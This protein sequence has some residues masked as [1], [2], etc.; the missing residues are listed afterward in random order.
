MAISRRALLIGS[1]ALGL[2]GAAVIVGYR[3]RREPGVAITQEPRLVGLWRFDET[4][5]NIATDASPFGNDGLLVAPPGAKVYGSGAFAGSVALG[6]AERS[7]VSILASESLNTLTNALTVVAYAYPR[8]LWTPAD[9]FDGHIALVQ[10]QWR[11][12]LHPDLFYLGY[13]PSNGVLTYKWHVGLVDEEPSIYERTDTRTPTTGA[14]VHLAGV[15][16]GE[17]GEMSL[18]VDG[19]LIATQ[20]HKGRIRLDAESLGRPVM[21]GGELNGEGLTEVSAPFNGHVGEVRIYH[22]ALTGAEVAVLASSTSP[23]GGDN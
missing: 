6:G 19:D 1:T 22:R 16:D 2:G 17:S 23:H 11:T 4:E 9:S 18:Y 13:G 5:G 14:W 7:F 10:R 20:T 15:Y 21:V 8:A 12:E 3:L